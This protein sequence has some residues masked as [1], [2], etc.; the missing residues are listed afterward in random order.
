MFS[1]LIKVCVL[2]LSGGFTYNMFTFL[3]IWNGFMKWKKNA[4]FDKGLENAVPDQF[5]SQWCVLH[6]WRLY[7]VSWPWEGEIKGSEDLSLFIKA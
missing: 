3:A 2:G 1:L 4:Y 6:A 5:K 7:V